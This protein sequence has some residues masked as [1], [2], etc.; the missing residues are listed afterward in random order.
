[1][2]VF[3]PLPACQDFF[4]R[5]Q[6]KF[7]TLLIFQVS[8]KDSSSLTV[9]S[10]NTFLQCMQNCDPLSFFI[11]KVNFI[12]ATS[13]RKHPKDSFAFRYP[14]PP[15][16]FSIIP[17]VSTLQTGFLKILSRIS[18]MIWLID[19]DK[20]ATI[21]DFA[22][23]NVIQAST[24]DNKPAMS[25]MAAYTTQHFKVTCSHSWGGCSPAE[26]SAWRY[27]TVKHQAARDLQRFPMIS[28][29]GIMSVV[30]VDN[31]SHLQNP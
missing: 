27:P 17:K 23:K 3:R 9:L 14:L 20:V 16:A 28:Q 5:R 26:G 11:E 4:I 10:S 7:P 1:M 13:C 30:I 25:L 15:G 29:Q 18:L 22:T 19:P 24:P 6:V 31:H 8:G 12:A 21:E 2:P